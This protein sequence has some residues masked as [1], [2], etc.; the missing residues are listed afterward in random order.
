MRTVP[1]PVTCERHWAGKQ[2]G[3]CQDCTPTEPAQR[4][5]AGE[6]RGRGEG[7]GGREA[8]LEEPQRRGPGITP[9]SLPATAGGRDRGSRQWMGGGGRSPH[10]GWR[11]PCPAV[12]FTR[13]QFEASGGPEPRPR[14][15]TSDVCVLDKPACI[16]PGR[17][18]SSLLR[19]PRL[20]PR[21]THSH[22]VGPQTAGGGQGELTSWRVGGEG[23]GARLP[24]LPAVHGAPGLSPAPR[25][26]SA[27][28][29]RAAAC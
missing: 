9:S 15:E 12:L 19:R 4:C 29:E 25:A 22:I 21:S 28:P 6:G 27:E 20:E 24:S 26:E 11:L 3:L 16:V 10:W 14:A 5:W 13:T 18:Q 8:W 17:V 2:S 23:R 1:C 7:R